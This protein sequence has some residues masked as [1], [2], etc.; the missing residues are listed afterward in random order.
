MPNLLHALRNL[1]ASALLAFVVLSAPAMVHAQADLPPAI[2]ALD[3]D[4]VL[5]IDTANGPIYVELLPDVA[6]QHV[7]RIRQLA[8]DGFYD[9]VVFHRVID[10]FMASVVIA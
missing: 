5:V 10:G 7:A 4:N 2:A 6:P 3:A 9:G 8:G 1:S